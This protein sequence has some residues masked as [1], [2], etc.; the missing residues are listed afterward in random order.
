M[1]E[2]ATIPA[3]FAQ[4]LSE[5]CTLVVHHKQQLFHQQFRS[6]N[7]LHFSMSGYAVARCHCE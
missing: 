5:E 3:I 2:D 6:H 7:L 4:L 1:F